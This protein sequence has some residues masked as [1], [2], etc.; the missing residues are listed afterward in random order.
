MSNI[1]VGKLAKCVGSCLLI[2]AGGYFI[3]KRRGAKQACDKI[4]EELEKEEKLEAK[5]SEEVVNE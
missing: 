3:G 2:F 5:E 1:N 4:V